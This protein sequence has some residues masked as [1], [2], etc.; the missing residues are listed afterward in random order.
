MIFQNATDSWSRW[1]YTNAP[2]A[3]FSAVAAV[4]TLVYVLRSRKKPKRIVV[5][6]TKNTTL[7][8]IW[9]SVRGNI[10]LFYSGRKINNLAQVNVD[11]FNEGSEVIQRPT[12]TVVLPVGCSVLAAV[13]EPEEEGMNHKIDQNKVTVLLPYLN[14]VSEHKH[15]WKLSILADGDTAKVTVSGGGE[16]WSVQHTTLPTAEQIAKWAPAITVGFLASMVF[17]FF[18]LRY[19]TMHF[20]VGPFEFSWR[21]LVLSFPGM[22]PTLLLM[23]STIWLVNRPS[24]SA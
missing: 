1:F 10:E 11:I 5:R 4:S 8:T 9:P 12:L 2:A 13:L 15:I 20:G 21:A 22:V 17:L 16:G 7:V 24:R 18:Y 19:I 14:P 23:A 3:W 6:E